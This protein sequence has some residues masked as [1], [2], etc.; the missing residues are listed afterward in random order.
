[1]VQNAL[2]R[3]WVESHPE[4]RE[5]I[6][7]WEFYLE[8]PNPES[9]FEEKIAPYINRELNIE[10]IKCLIQQWEVGISL[11]ICLMYFMRFILNVDIWNVKY[12]D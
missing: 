6:G 8:N 12:R 7:K 2:G 3:Y 4:H 9:D 11:R 1:M 5:L 10:D